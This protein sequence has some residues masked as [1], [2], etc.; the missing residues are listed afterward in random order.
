MKTIRSNISRRDFLKQSSAGIIG[1]S[2][3]GF[4]SLCKQQKFDKMPMRTLG[5]TGLEVSILSFGGGSQF[6]KNKDGDWES[7][8][9]KAVESGINF[10]D[11]SSGYQWGASMSSEERFGRI[12]PKYRDNI[13]ISTKFESR[14]PDEAKKEIER[15]LKHMRTDYI[16]ILMIHSIEPSEDIAVL[17]KGVYKMMNQ[18][19]D[20]G[21]VRFIG[22]SCMNSSQKSKELIEKLDIDVALLA[23]NPTKYGDFAEVALPAANKKN[24]GVIAMKVMRN[25]VGKEATPGELLQYAWTQPGVATSMIGHFGRETLLENIRI[26]NKFVSEKK[27]EI[28]RK[29]LETRLSHLAGPHVLCW[30]R[31]GY[32]DGM[33]A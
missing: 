7:I 6:L 12:L 14:K 8:L 10:F 32:H 21:V 11:T 5:K 29:T 15:S 28:N 30:A 1:L 18:L 3:I 24:V 23:M 16:D 13:I 31:P 20:E 19:K 17:E 26:V 33:V 4:F 22:F 2:S 9:E 25:I 27:V